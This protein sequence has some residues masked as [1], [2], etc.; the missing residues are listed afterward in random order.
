MSD[1]SEGLKAHLESLPER[2]WAERRAL[3]IASNPDTP[4]NARVLFRL[5][6]HTRKEA[7]A[8]GIIDWLKNFDWAKWL[9]VILSILGFLL[10]FA[11]PAPEGVMEAGPEEMGWAPGDQIVEWIISSKVV[12]TIKAAIPG[13][14]I[15]SDEALGAWIL[16][17]YKAGQA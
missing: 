3:R 4:H 8:T 13:F 1:F 2:G 11:E 16:E 15:Q 17:R 9:P 14:P 6:A 7:G 10:M 12:P 5:E